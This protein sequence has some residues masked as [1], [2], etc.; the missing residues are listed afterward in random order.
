MGY[1]LFRWS[2]QQEWIH[3]VRGW[4]D[5]LLMTTWDE[6]TI[7][8]LEMLV[9]R[10]MAQHCSFLSP[11]PGLVSYQFRCKWSCPVGPIFKTGSYLFSAHWPMRSEKFSYTVSLSSYI[12][13]L[14]RRP[15]PAVHS[16]NRF[17][18]KITPRGYILPYGANF[19]SKPLNNGL[20]PE[21]LTTVKASKPLLPHR[22]KIVYIMGSHRHIC[23]CTK[24]Y[25]FN[26]YWWT[27]PVSVPFRGY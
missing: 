22:V 2:Q 23:G 14:Y 20:S 1:S 21:E 9:N 12:H 8:T 18:P 11:F 17:F 4:Q 19:S 5:P 27:C 16:S 10:A 6:T 15:L 7:W 25:F 24:N 3:R 26:H 13:S